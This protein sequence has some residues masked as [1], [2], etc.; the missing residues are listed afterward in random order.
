MI[1]SD[2][3]GH[4]GCTILLCESDDG[5][6]FVRK[7]SGSKEYNERLKKQ[8]DKQKKYKGINIK[9]PKVFKTGYTKEGL[10]YFDMEY[11]RGITLAEYIKEIEIGKIRGIAEI[12]ALNILPKR[13]KIEYC[14]DI[15]TE[16]INSLQYDLNSQDNPVVKNALSVLNQHN[17]NE[18]V[19]SPC[20]GDMTLENIIVKGDQLFFIDFLDS[21]YDSWILDAGTLLQDTQ[22]M[23]AYRNENVNMNT[24]I[25]LMV[26][27][28]ILIDI[29]K[30]KMGEK[31]IEIYYALLLKLIRIYPYTDDRK[32]VQFCDEKVKMTLNLIKQS[33]K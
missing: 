7:I 18:F 5:E 16:K 13:V 26:F 24:I 30:A 11:I 32:T 8:A 12:L 25:R 27:R 23:W 6:A 20:H 28:D 22:A 29:F 21:F 17:W 1:Q 2:L 3:H 31:Y 33:E 19:I 14:Q 9:S 4:S 15:F 10:F